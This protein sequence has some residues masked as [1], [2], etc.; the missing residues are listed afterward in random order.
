[1]SIYANEDDDKSI[2]EIAEEEIRMNY[3]RD[4]EEFKANERK[5]KRMLKN[6]LRQGQKHILS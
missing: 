3:G 1:M 2:F 4:I 5:F 6:I